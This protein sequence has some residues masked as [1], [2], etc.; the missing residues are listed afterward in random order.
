MAE[1]GRAGGRLL[2][3]E[4]GAA[5]GL[6]GELRLRSFTQNPADIGR[7]GPLQDEA[8]KRQFEI[9]ALRD[10]PKALIAKF[11]GVDDRNAAEALAGVKLYAARASLPSAEADEFYYADLIGLEAI[12]PEGDPLGTVVALH[13]F[14]AGDIVELAPADGGPTLLI[15]FTAATV[16]EVNI[17]D[18]YLVLVPPEEL[19]AREDAGA[20]LS[21]AE[22][23][24]SAGPGEGDEQ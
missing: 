13:N 17:A 10:G 2:L 19:A 9:E 23:G 5:H 18:G 24:R 15:P 1:D 20:H 7:Y 8:G 12:G 3:G 16:P 22:R 14:C 4:I 11:K 6:R 21:P